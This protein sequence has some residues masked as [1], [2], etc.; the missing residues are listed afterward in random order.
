MR[1]YLC[2]EHLEG[3]VED[4]HIPA[5]LLFPHEFRKARNLQLVTRPVHPRCHGP[6]GRDE[7]YFLQHV[8]IPLAHDT[9]A[10]MAARTEFR[11]A[12]QRPAGRVVADRVRSEFDDRPRGLDLPDGRMVKRF[13]GVRAH[14]AVWK[15]TRGLFFVETQGKFLPA[16]TPKDI[17]VRNE[18]HEHFPE[19]T[20]AL[21]GEPSRGHSP[22]LFDYKI[23]MAECAD[24]PH[25][26]LMRLWE[27]LMVQVAFHDPA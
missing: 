23:R 13:D 11:R 3:S 10:G 6:T 21:M 2:G 4:D 22:E 25:F 12:I 16:Q 14:S 8:L 26:L 24:E 15:W 5:K 18:A 20:I 27:R 7:D 19:L 9:P 1:C 17:Q